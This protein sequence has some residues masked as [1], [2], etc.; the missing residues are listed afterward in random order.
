MPYIPLE[1]VE[2]SNIVAI[3]YHRQS[4]TLGIRF[5]QDRYYDYPMVPQSEYELLMAAESKGKFFN[6]RIKPM[7]GHCS[8]REEALQEPCCEHRGS[9]TCSTECFPCKEWCCPGGPTAETVKAVAAAV[10]LGMKT[11]ASLAAAL[12]A[13]VECECPDAALNCNNSCECPCHVSPVSPPVPLT[14]DGEIDMDQIPNVTHLFTED[15]DEA[16]ENLT[17]S[18]VDDTQSESD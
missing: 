6:T 3:G 17:D 8:V 9:D 15:G 14:E 5:Q 18:G 2:S 16:E 7:Y 10:T 12:R 4:Q 13:V 1:E 11:G